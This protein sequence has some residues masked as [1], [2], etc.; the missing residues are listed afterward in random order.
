MNDVDRRVARLNPV[1]LVDVSGA[2][3]T[4][5]AVLLLERLLDQ[6]IPGSRRTRSPGLR[7]PRA[8]GRRL[9]L[10]VLVGVALVL[11][12][13]AIGWAITATSAR[14][15]VSVQC[16]SAGGDTIIP[17]VTGDPVADCAAQWR[18][19]TGSEP[20]PLV[21]YDNGHGG[22]TVAPA[23]RPALPGA[24]PLPD[25][26]TQNEAIVQVQRSLD[27]LVGGLNSGCFDNPTAVEMTTGI[28]ARFGMQD[29]TVNPAPPA[30]LS[31]SS[32]SQEPCVYTVIL[33][34][35][36]R[37]VTLRALGG[38]LPADA[39]YSKLAARLR[40]LSTECMPLDAMTERVGAILD[41]LGISEAR[42]EVERTEIPEH[43]APC[44]TVTETVGGSIFLVLRGPAA[45]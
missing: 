4:T 27:D 40:S 8:A 11:A 5:E 9:R 10:P 21:A 24:T 43:D 25:G 34:P 44:T 20:P 22:I 31:G 33:D 12:G 28:L 38:A 7:H 30:D 32:G 18:R 23:D 14:D 37:T 2:E 19:D 13:T 1:P 36:T 35:A 15:T 29:W 26:A 6:P 41:E 39:P 16:L 42:H 3:R 45:S 17:A